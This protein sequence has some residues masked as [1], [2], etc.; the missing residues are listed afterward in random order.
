LSNVQQL[1]AVNGKRREL[2]AK[3]MRTFELSRHI[4]HLFDLY[5]KQMQDLAIEV[6]ELRNDK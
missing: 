4:Q 5:A 6:L 3:I 1:P 2:H